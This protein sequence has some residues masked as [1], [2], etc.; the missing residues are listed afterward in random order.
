MCTIFV[1][2]PSQCVTHVI[3]PLI[4]FLRKVC[5][6]SEDGSY[7]PRDENAYNETPTRSKAKAPVATHVQQPT[8]KIDSLEATAV[9]PMIDN[10]DPTAVFSP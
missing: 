2:M 6:S 9:R 4:N 10:I 7:S 3:C 8:P 5:H 1:S